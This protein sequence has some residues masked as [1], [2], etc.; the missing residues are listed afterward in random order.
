MPP[1][2]LEA[3]LEYATKLNW[4]VFPCEPGGKRPLGRL[5]PNGHLDAT[6]DPDKIRAWWLAEPAANV[7]VAL[8]PSWLV[9]LDIDAANGK[10]GHESA[11]EIDHLL[12]PTWTARTPRDGLHGLY[13]RPV[14]VEP[15]RRIGFRPG[16]DLLGDGYVVL[17]PSKLLGGGTY[18]WVNSVA[19]APVPRALLELAEARPEPKKVEAIREPIITGGRNNSLY[20]LACALRDLGIEKE[21]LAAALHW[22]NQQ[23][24][25]P[26]VDDLELT[27][28]VDSAMRTV[29]T[30][31]R[32]VAMGALVAQQVLEAIAPKPARHQYRELALERHTPIQFIPTGFADLDVL[33]GGGMA[34]QSVVGVIG[35]PSSG[36]SAFVGSLIMELQ[37]HRPVLDVS[38]E[39]P[40]REV[41]VRR[42]AFKLGFAWRLGIS[43]KIDSKLMADAVSDLRGEVIGCDDL[44]LNDPIGQIRREAEAMR[45]QNGNI[46]PIIVVDYVQLLARASDDK[47][48]ALV[49]E[50][51]KQLRIMAQQLDTVVVAV[52]SSRRD[53]YGEKLGAL[54]GNDSPLMFLSAAKESGDIEFDCATLLY[55]DVD[56]EHQGLPKPARI[57]VARCRYGDVGFAGARAAL[58]IGRWLSD[59]AAAV[60]MTKES[61]RER[62]DLSQTEHD[63]QRCLDVI[64]RTP[65]RPWRERRTMGGIDIKRMDAAKAKLLETGRIAEVKQKIH[66]NMGRTVTRLNLVIVE[67]AEDV[68]APEA[69]DDPSE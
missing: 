42:A 11:A 3:A 30:P 67:G 7:A 8:A 62:K 36:K 20:K 4:F 47:R 39:L 34:T 27:A 21:A 18:A 28:I 50:L 37:K 13:G 29:A 25:K 59:P 23:R 68:S 46:A 69:S 5:V 52:F 38:T 65:G 51:T 1:S 16:L 41:M 55:L 56:Q 35:P 9:A 10:K 61:R 17:A 32:D 64:K 53:F 58:D 43:G 26:P 48:R 66:D 2:L 33:L 22:E 44:D 54:R 19:I 24:C 63:I 31:S 14:D 49:G 12:T 15:K 40:A 45:A 60:E 6:R 57:A